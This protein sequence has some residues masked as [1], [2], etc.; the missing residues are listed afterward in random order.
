MRRKEYIILITIAS[1][2]DGDIRHIPLMEQDAVDM[3][4]RSEA[5]RQFWEYA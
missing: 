5:G 1:F 2:I 3:I 4:V